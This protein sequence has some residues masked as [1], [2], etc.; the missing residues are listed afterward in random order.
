LSGE[1]ELMLVYIRG[2]ASNSSWVSPPGDAH[3][4]H[5]VLDPLGAEAVGVHD[6]VGE[7]QLVEEA[8]RDAAR[9]VHVDRLHRIAAGEM[10]AVEVYCVSLSRSR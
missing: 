8:R 2:L 1:V 10:D 5:H 4:L 9:G 3:H 7:R 6:L